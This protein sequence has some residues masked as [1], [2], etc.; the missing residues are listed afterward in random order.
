MLSDG[1]EICVIIQWIIIQRLKL[2]ESFKIA[3]KAFTRLSLE[4]WILVE[5]HDVVIFDFNRN[6]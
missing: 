3:F 6:D 4:L 5:Y 2:V 1:K